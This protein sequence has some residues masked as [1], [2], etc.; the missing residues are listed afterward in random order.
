MSCDATVG[1][2]ALLSPSHQNAENVHVNV[3]NN[4]CWL[5]SLNEDFEALAS[6]AVT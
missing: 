1:N 4:D 5:Q 3:E 2:E 6:N